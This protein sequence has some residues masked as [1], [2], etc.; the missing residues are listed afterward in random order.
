MG[1]KGI[2]CI[3]VG[4]VEHSKAY[5]FYVIEPNNSVSINEI[6]ESRDAT[7]DESRFSSIP[8]LKDVILNSNKSQRGD[9]SNDVPSET[10]K[11]RKS[12][13]ARKAKS[14]EAIND[15]IGLIMENNTWV[16]SNLLPG[17]R[18]K[19]G[20]DYFNTY[21][22]V[23]RIT[24]IRFL[25]ALVAIH[26][27]VIYQMDFKI[28]FL[29]GNLEEEVYMKQLEGFVIP[30][31]EH[32]KILKKFNR[33]D[34][35]LVSTPMDPVEKLIPNTAGRLSR[36]TSN[37]SRQHWYAITRI[38]K[39][40]NVNGCFFLGDVI[41]W[42]SKKKTCINVST[43]ESEFVALH[44]V[45]KEAEWLR[46]LIHEIIIWLKPIASISIHYDSVATLAKAYS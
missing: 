8:R 2:Y 45:G 39:Y 23:S 27:L 9:H 24:I 43:M 32:K 29:N 17:F 42:A 18:K 35:S 28:A 41:S 11:P 44:A 1:E 46:N 21:A 16:L 15:D 14:Y 33:E 10:L 40:L 30:S 3:F 38:F 37:P 13:R 26:N 22:P 7:F 12:K 34:C 5:R 19:E 25:L 4:N 20:I 6:I 31:N 36:F